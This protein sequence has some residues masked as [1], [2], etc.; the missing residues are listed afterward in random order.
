VSGSYQ[1]TP[2]L[3]FTIANNWN[4]NDGSGYVNLTA[5]Y[6]VSGNATVTAGAFIRYG[7]KLSEYWYYPNSYYLEGQ[8]FF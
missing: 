8:L 3:T 6:S 4:L 1:Y 2:L 5:A 7:D